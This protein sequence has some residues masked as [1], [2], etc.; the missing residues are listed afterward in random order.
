MLMRMDREQRVAYILDIVFGL[1]SDEAAAVLDI[2]AAAYRKRLS[3]AR[4]RL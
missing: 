2:A 3:R 1:D 4:A